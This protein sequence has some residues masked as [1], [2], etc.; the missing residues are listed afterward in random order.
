MPRAA[1]I[2]AGVYAAIAISLFAAAAWRLHGQNSRQAAVFAA[3]GLYALVRL[4]MVLRR[5]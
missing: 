5:R 2:F 4:F 1:K 3:G